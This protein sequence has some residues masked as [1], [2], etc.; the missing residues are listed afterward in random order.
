MSHAFPEG[1]TLHREN[2]AILNATLLG[3]AQS[4]FTELNEKLI[5]R[6]LTAPL[7][8]TRNDGSFMHGRRSY[9]KTFIGL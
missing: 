7:F 5:Q 9:H 3:K 1:G 4:I 2:A 8:V 6:G